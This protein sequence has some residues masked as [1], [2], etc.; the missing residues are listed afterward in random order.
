M[1]EIFLVPKDAGNYPPAGC[2]GPV[3]GVYDERELLE[4]KKATDWFLVKVWK[5][6]WSKPKPLPPKADE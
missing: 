2:Q 6:L 1:K 3:V 5:N 4:P